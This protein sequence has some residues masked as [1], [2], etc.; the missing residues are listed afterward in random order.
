[1]KA[2]ALGYWVWGLGFWGVHASCPLGFKVEGVP[3][4]VDLV[5]VCFR[6]AHVAFTFIWGENVANEVKPL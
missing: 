5:W 1:M 4:C 3:R 6:E 2:E